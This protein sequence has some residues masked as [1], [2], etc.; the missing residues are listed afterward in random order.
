LAVRKGFRNSNRA[1]TLG[2]HRTGTLEIAERRWGSE[3]EL[4]A[5]VFRELA[6]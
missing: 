2:G 5:Q 4:L 6:Q 1:V 3:R